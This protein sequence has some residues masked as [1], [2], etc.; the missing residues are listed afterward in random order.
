MTSPDFT[1]PRKSLVCL[2]QII[3][4]VF[5]ANPSIMAKF[6]AKLQ[7]SG[8]MTLIRPF[9]TQPRK[10]GAESG[11]RGANT[12]SSTKRCGALALLYKTNSEA[13]DGKRGKDLRTAGL[14]ATQCKKGRHD[15]SDYC[16]QHSKNIPDEK[17][18]CQF[19]T[20]WRGAYVSHTKYTDCMGTIE[21]PT[22]AFAYN[23][24]KFA[25]KNRRVTS[26]NHEEEDKPK[27]RPGRPSKKTKDDEPMEDDEH[28]DSDDNE[29]NQESNNNKR[30]EPEPEDDDEDEKTDFFDATDDHVDDHPNGFLVGTESKIV[31][32][33]IGTKKNPKAGPDPIGMEQDDNIAIFDT[34]K[35]KKSKSKK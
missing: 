19:C 35:N 10:A 21:A 13:D 26:T 28:Q 9:Y 3:Q 11:S 7:E 33:N 32:A 16:A 15:E 29:L 8:D 14:V 5:D 27:K 23:H 25:S 31:Y 18:F 4:D 34:H 12:I 30:K 17:Q 2:E 6:R 20:K 24:H 22:G 1:T